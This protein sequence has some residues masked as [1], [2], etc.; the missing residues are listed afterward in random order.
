MKDRIRRA[1]RYLVA[2]IAIA[3]A[4]NLARAASDVVPLPEL[5][6][7]PIEMRVAYVVNSRLPRMNQAQLEILLTATRNAVREH[8]G[9]DLRFAPMQVIPIETLFERIP[10]KRRSTAFE[11]L[12][13]FKTGKGDSD[14]LAKAFGAGFKEGGEPL[15][16]LIAFARPHIAELK[17]R[18]YEALGVAL[19]GLQLSRIERWKTIKALDG[20]PAIDRARSL[21]GHREVERIEQ[22]IALTD[23][24]IEVGQRHD[25]AARGRQCQSEPEPERAEERGIGLDVDTV[26]RVC[27][28]FATDPVLIIAIQGG[29]KRSDA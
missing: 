27:D 29:A 22:R 16:D 13:D 5:P 10:A 4:W 23:P 8:F 24:A 7:G 20:G 19:S 11:Q 6:P 18:S 21:A 2:V 12:Y 17:E 9:V 15:A 1:G 14:R 26:Q 28:D 3:L 25:R